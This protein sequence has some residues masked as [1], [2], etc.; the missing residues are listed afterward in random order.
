MEWGLNW[1]SAPGP[2]ASGMV[3]A[4]ACKASEETKQ[5]TWASELLVHLKVAVLID[6]CQVRVPTFSFFFSSKLEV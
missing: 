6:F 2:Q 4:D 5:V 1:S 3:P